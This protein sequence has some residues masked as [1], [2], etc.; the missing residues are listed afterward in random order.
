[1]K[2]NEGAARRGAS[3]PPA[4]CGGGRAG[5]EPGRAADAAALDAR[6]RSRTIT[7]RT[8]IIYRKAPRRG[9]DRLPRTAQG[10]ARPDPSPGADLPSFAGDQQRDA[11]RVHRV[12]SRHRRPGQ[13]PGD[14]PGADRLC[15]RRSA[16]RPRLFQSP[17][18]ALEWHCLW[19]AREY[20]RLQRP[21][22]GWRTRPKPEPRK[23]AAGGASGR[24]PRREAAI[25]QHKRGA[26]A[27]PA[28]QR[29][30][31]RGRRRRPQASHERTTQ[32][33]AKV[34]NAVASYDVTT[35]REDLA[36]AIYNISPVDTPFM[37]RRPARQGFGRAARMVDRFDR[38]HQHR[39]CP[40]RR[41]RA[42][43]APPRPSPARKQ[44]Y[45]QISSRD[46]T[47]TGTERAVNPAG[48]DD[49]MAYQ[50]SK[51]SLAL[52]KDME[53]ILLGNQGQ[54][55]GDTTTA[56]KLRS[57]NAWIS[58]NGN[59]GT[60]GADSTAAT[61]AATDGT[62]GDIR[63]L[64]EAML[65][66]AIKDAFDDGGEPTLVPGRRVQQ[67]GRLGLRRPSAR[68]RRSSTT[69]RS[70]AP[71]RSTRPTSA[72]SRSCPTAPSAAAT[73]SSSIPTRWRWRSC[74]RSSRRSSAGSA[75]R[76]PATSSANIRSRCA[77]PTPTRSSPIW[78]RRQFLPRIGGGGPARSAVEGLVRPRPAQPLHQPSL[79]LRL[80]PLPRRGRKLASRVP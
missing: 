4:L 34:T 6:H 29:R 15:G 44:N 33:M 43:P 32:L 57:F 66:D 8:T 48:I 64:T 53:A 74:A 30:Q 45:C 26:G 56:R 50:M 18:T 67:A 51:K 37:S 61:A 25:E 35:N 5:A 59:R 20:D 76:S 79:K 80:V 3:Q 10:P 11:R 24:R 17:T 47:V 28:A 73:C 21:R 39:Q 63:T 12:G 71:P 22:R 13:G 46:A 55:A 68:S 78:R 42:E 49:M 2:A 60:N 62:A 41:R 9:H 77:T 36:D 19:K 75:T 72:T 31:R 38:H 1:M 69:R 14:L 70:S 16:R 52:R 58:G 23:A 54:V 27:G 65:K 7:T 40:A